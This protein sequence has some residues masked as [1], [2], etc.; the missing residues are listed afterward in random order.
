MSFVFNTHVSLSNLAVLK[1]ES[2]E[3]LPCGLW[4]AA[5]SLVEQD[6]RSCFQFVLSVKSIRH[7]RFAQQQVYVALR[8]DI[9]TEGPE[10]A[11]PTASQRPEP[12]RHSFWHPI[13][14]GGLLCFQGPGTNPSGDH[15]CTGKQEGPWSSGLKTLR[16]LSYLKGVCP[17]P[18]LKFNC[19]QK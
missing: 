8:K 19:R 12:P 4:K 5:Q 15:I 13:T 18:I 6:S 10:L 16:V 9:R 11:Q 7:D 1:L 3:W 17:V 2:Q 14:A